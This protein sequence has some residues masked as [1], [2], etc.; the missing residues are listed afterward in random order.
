MTNLK[1]LLLSMTVFAM[2]LG[3]TLSGIAFADNQNG[4]YSHSH[5]TA[6]W[7][8]N[9]VCGNH[10]CVSGEV[11]KNPPVVIPVKGIQ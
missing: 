5:M 2:S 3:S 9:I 4:M 11:S 10:T 7:E 1:K 6:L 8:H